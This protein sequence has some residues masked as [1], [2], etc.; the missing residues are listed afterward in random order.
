M[1][2]SL[3]ALRVSIATTVGVL[4]LWHGVAFVSESL[5]TWHV[6]D[7]HGRV[8]AGVFGVV[9]CLFQYPQAGTLWLISLVADVA[10][11]HEL[12]RPHGYLPISFLVMVFSVLHL[13]LT[14]FAAFVCVVWLGIIWPARVRKRL[15][16]YPMTWKKVCL[17]CL[18]VTSGSIGVVGGVFHPLFSWGTVLSVV[19]YTLLFTGR[20]IPE[21]LNGAADPVRYGQH[22]DG[23]WVRLDPLGALH[24]LTATFSSQ[25]RRTVQHDVERLTHDCFDDSGH[26][27]EEEW[28][29]TYTYK[30]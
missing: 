11:Y 1:E 17:W 7:W 2:D 26:S 10:G 28:S 22:P 14:L 3:D 25:D 24:G 16:Q 29:S 5:P 19:L 20:F 13:Y 21:V 23:G 15:Y 6:F 9:A 30:A 27:A 12:P 18:I 8:L 4:H